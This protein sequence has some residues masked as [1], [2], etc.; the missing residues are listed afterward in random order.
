MSG[1]V[2]NAFDYYDY[3]ISVSGKIDLNVNDG[4]FL[5]VLIVFI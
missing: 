2:K 1:I 5:K 3:L 4:F